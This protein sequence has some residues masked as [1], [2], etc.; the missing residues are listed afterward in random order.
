MK[1][2]KLIKRMLISYPS[3]F[4]NKQSCLNHLFLT[5]GNGYEWENG[6]LVSDVDNKENENY[7]ENGIKRRFNFFRNALSVSWNML[8]RTDTSENDFDIEFIKSFIENGLQRLEEDMIECT[9]KNLNYRFND[10]AILKDSSLYPLS[11]YAKILNIPEDITPEWRKCAKDYYEFLKSS[12]DEKMV[13]WREENKE[14]FN[15][16]KI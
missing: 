2:D 4:T 10:M 6:E 11:I 5:N 15:K 1:P 13:K 14:L 16:I 12:E 3:L 7:I 8:K 9:P